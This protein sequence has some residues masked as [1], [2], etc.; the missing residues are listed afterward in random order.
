[1]AYLRHSLRGTRNDYL[2]SIAVLRTRLWALLQNGDVEV[3]VFLGFL[4]SWQ[5]I[6]R[7]AL[8]S[9]SASR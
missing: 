4:V 6:A 7:L 2:N 9:L 3:G 8:P 1:M 5:L